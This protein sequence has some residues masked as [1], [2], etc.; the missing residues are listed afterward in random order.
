MPSY[1][2]ELTVEIVTNWRQQAQQKTHNTWMSHTYSQN[3]DDKCRVRPNDA[4]RMEM[5]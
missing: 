5:K 2:R 1:L 3:V 4:G